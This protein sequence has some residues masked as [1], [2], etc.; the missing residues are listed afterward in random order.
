M[1]RFLQ[2][3]LVLL[4]FSVSLKA[5]ASYMDGAF[6]AF[7]VIYSILVALLG[8]AVTLVLAAQGRFKATGLLITY[9]LFWITAWV[10]ALISVAS[11]TR[12]LNDPESVV[13]T[14]VGEGVLVFIILLP[15]LVQAFRGRNSAQGKSN[16]KRSSDSEKSA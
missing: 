12:N 16:N 1:G 15:A 14:L 11:P 5:S 6:G 7:L 4:L 10:V 2:I 8:F 3:A 9:C 13:T